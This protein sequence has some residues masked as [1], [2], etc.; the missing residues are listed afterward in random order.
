MKTLLLLLTLITSLSTY[1]QQQSVE[2]FFFFCCNRVQRK[3]C[4]TCSSNR[5]ANTDSTT[6]TNYSLAANIQPNP[7]KGSLAIEVT[8]TTFIDNKKQGNTLTE[9]THFHVIVYDIYGREILN[10]QHNTTQF[11]IDITD[12]P[13]GAYFVKLFTANK[14]KQWEI[15][16]D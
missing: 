10:E 4:M 6:T 8:E 16:K 1:A 11:K 14:V 9:A 12:R 13:P 15:I 7:T 3:L 5:P 2:Y